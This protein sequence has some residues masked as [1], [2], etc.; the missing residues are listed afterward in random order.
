MTYSVNLLREILVKID[1]SLLTNNILVL[2]FIL[3][4]LTTINI[5]IS[6]KK[7]ESRQ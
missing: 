6:H 5:C 4:L 3:V 2:G 7:Q 1:M